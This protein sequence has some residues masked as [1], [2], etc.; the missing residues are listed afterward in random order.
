MSRRHYLVS[1]DVADDK[2]RTRLFNLL[3]GEGDHVQYSVFFC[4]CNARE[5]AQLRAE[6]TGII[7]SREDQVLLLDL[8]PADAPLDEGLEVF[9]LP[10]E[11]S[12][13]TIV[14]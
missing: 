1:Y 14:V 3:Q 9:G 6:I 12:V 5:C 4:D 13:R 11:P 7:H 10:Y 8:G 2:R